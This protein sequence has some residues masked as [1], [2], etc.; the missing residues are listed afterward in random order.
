MDFDGA[1]DAVNLG[2]TLA[3]ARENWFP[4]KPLHEGRGRRPKRLKHARFRSQQQR[5]F[6]AGIMHSIGVYVDCLGPHKN[7]I[8]AMLYA[9]NLIDPDTPSCCHHGV[10]PP[11]KINTAEAAAEWLQHNVYAAACVSSAS[12]AEPANRELLHLRDDSVAAKLD[13]KGRRCIFA[14]DQLVAWVLLWAD[15]RLELRWQGMDIGFGIFTTRA[16]ADSAQIRLEAIADYEMRD[17]H[18]P[19]HVHA[20]S[21][22]RKNGDC[23]WDYVS[24][25]GPLTLL[26]ASCE[27]H[28]VVTLHDE[29]CGDG[30]KRLFTKRKTRKCTKRKT[31]ECPVPLAESQQLL[32]YYSSPEGQSWQCPGGPD[33]NRCCRARL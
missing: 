27:R 26:N 17:P 4:A 22:D 21:S 1:G 14:E 31:S 2:T 15:R 25:F 8:H 3:R 30:C 12:R 20:T 7:E 11:E 10:R 6:A 29:D 28:A 19:A 18:A 13:E 33:P 5:A 9:R 24:A 23:S 16:V 32:L